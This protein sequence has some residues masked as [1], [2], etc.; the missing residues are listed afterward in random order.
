[1]NKT[2]QSTRHRAD[3]VLM[4]FA[5]VP[6]PGRVKTRLTTLLSA[7]DAARVYTAF[8]KDALIQYQTLGVD[9]HLFL[10]PSDVPVPEG[11]VPEDVTIHEQAGQGLG[12]RMSNAF[13][14]TFS[15]GYQRIVIIGTDHPTLPSEYIQQAFDALARPEMVV[16]GPSEDG[17]YYLLGMNSFRPEL[18]Q[19]MHY[20]HDSV[21]QQTLARINTIT[22]QCLSL[23]V[24][25]DVDTPD[26]LRRLITSIHRAKQG[27]LPHTRALLP[28]LLQKYS[29]LR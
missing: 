27:A 5:K 21:Y 17:G 29:S 2:T 28:L 7:E 22:V 4:V 20:S 13:K 25:F 12:Q 15:Q 19:D 16:I 18:F 6:V 3:T 14:Q 24:W 26:E 1:M 10:A 11:I 8:L 23:P 9:V